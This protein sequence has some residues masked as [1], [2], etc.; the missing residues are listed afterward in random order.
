MFP[1]FP[2]RLLTALHRKGI[3]DD[4]RQQKFLGHLP[5]RLSAPTRR[6]KFRDWSWGYPK[7][8]LDGFFQGKS[9]RKWMI[10]G[11]PPIG[12][13]TSTCWF[14][15]EAMTWAMS[16]SSEIST[17]MGWHNG[18]VMRPVPPKKNLGSIAFGGMFSSDLQVFHGFPG[19][20]KDWASSQRFP[21]PWRG[22]FQ[23]SSS[24]GVGLD[25]SWE[26][27][28]TYSLKLQI[29]WIWWLTPGYYL[30]CS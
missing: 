28:L 26:W 14:E 13:E 10:L 29:W 19:L 8:A 20:N 4:G 25:L 12:L 16:W 24:T 30:E 11:V 7:R 6:G 1:T 27:L 23:E 17:L 18:N 2:R 21:L 9:Q 5:Q 3:A 22:E 15:S